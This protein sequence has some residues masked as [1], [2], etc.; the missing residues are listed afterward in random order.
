[1]GPY[2]G[3]LKKSESLELIDEHGAIL[4]TV[5][6]S[7]VYP[8]P[9]AT[10]GTGHSLVLA[11]PTYGEAD[12]RA[13]DISD[14]TGGSPGALETF[15]PDP[16][17]DVVINEL[18]A[19]TENAAVSDFVELYNHSS[20]TNDLSGCI[21]TDDPA[22]NKFAIPS[23]T[24]IGPG[25]F[26]SFERAQLGFGLRAEGETVYLLKTDRSRVLDAA[27]FEAQADGVSYGRWPD[28]ANDLYA[29][30]TR[31]PGAANSPISISDIF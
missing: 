3:S 15:R 8:W 28:G 5:L 14:V 16:L 12:P 11:N 9:V 20:Q 30:A 21:L 13:W 19:H 22:V 7:N 10:G 18:L 1:M 4:L 17:R 26:V 31:T 27:Q 24:S 29:L 23:G 25:G 6:Y 2:T